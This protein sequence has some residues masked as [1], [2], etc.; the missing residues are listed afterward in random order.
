MP[1]WTGSRPQSL[2]LEGRKFAVPP[3]TLV[4]LNITAVH[5][6]PRYWGPDAHVWRPSRWIRS[7]S[8]VS[9]TAS[10][11]LSKSDPNSIAFGEESLAMPDPKMFFPWSDGPHVCPGRRFAQVEFVAVL[12][13]VLQRHSVEP[14]QMK[15]EDMAQARTR[16]EQVLGD[17]VFNLTL[18][19]REP[20]KIRMRLVERSKDIP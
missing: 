18:S 9:S 11:T 2:T 17:C 13:T 7:S 15:G 5:T 3:K 14:V 1:K 16:V 4:V 20:E 10:D 12:S 6:N 8:S 19:M